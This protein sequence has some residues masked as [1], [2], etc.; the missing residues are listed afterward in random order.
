MRISEADL[1]IV[2]GWMNS[3]PDHW[4]SRW[5]KKLS[6]ARRVE[7][8]DF[9]KPEL[10]GWIDA[11]NAAVRNA[12]RPVVFVAH[13]CGAT[14]IAHAAPRLPAGVVR[15]AMF[16]APPDRLCGPAIDALA[17]EGGGVARPPQG[18][19]PSPMAALPFP[20]I[21]VASRTDPICS[22]QRAEEI[23]TAWKSELID[24]GDAGHINAASGYGPWPEG[25]LRLADFM[26]RLS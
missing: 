22:F 11:L 7:M 5:E 2:P 25:V 8:P 4:Q 15:G 21:L 16:V 1:L 20:S 12:R 3:S 10:A 17:R 14:A 9:D 18:F 13:S 6:T 23:A 24:A 26:R 19:D